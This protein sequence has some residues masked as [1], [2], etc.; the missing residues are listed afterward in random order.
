MAPRK[1]TFATARKIAARRVK[2]KKQR[3]T[4]QRSPLGSLIVKG[5]NAIMSAIPAAKIFKPMTDFLFKS[6]GF[7]SDTLRSGRFTATTVIY[8]LGA[9]FGLPLSSI[10]ENAPILAKH[11]DG[12]KVQLFTNFTHGQL[13]QV[14][15]T[16]RPIGQ[17]AHRQGNIAL[18]FIPYTTSESG[19]YYTGSTVD[20]PTLQDVL[21]VP[22]AVQG[23]GTRTLSINY[24][25]RGLQFCNTPHPL[26]TEIGLVLIGYQ[27][28]SRNKG[29]EFDAEDFGAEVIIS[30]AVRLSNPLPHVGYAAVPC[31][32]S[33]KLADKTI[34]IGEYY[35]S[36]GKCE[37]KDDRVKVT[38]VFTPSPFAH[39]MRNTL[40]EHLGF[41]GSQGSPSSLVSKLLDAT[42][43][44]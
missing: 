32:L 19:R 35:V 9:A 23:S 31:G 21:V 5:V 43:D 27:D 20:I 22:G 6:V 38:G 3:R 34:R 37:V 29:S 17:L 26:T 7:T 42:L 11:H 8:G 30:G 10:I 4:P 39:R 25:A 36:D 1:A 14:R 24:R 28:L 2:P 18:A 41:D 40:E 13:L 44:A 33:D 16:V 15:I 12:N